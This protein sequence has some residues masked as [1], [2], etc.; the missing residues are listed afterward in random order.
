[1]RFEG[2]ARILSNVSPQL[3]RFVADGNRSIPRFWK[4]IAGVEVNRRHTVSAAFHP[5]LT[6]GHASPLLEQESDPTGYSSCRDWRPIEIRRLMAGDVQAISNNLIEVRAKERRELTPILPETAV[7]LGELARDLNPEDHI[8]VARR[9]RQGR[10]EPLG[11]DGMRDLIKRLMD[12]AGVRGLAGYDLRKTFATLVRSSCGDEFLTMRLLRDQIPGVGHRYI[13]F[14][15]EQLVAALQQHSPISQ[16]ERVT[17]H[18][19]RG[20]NAPGEQ[21]PPTSSLPIEKP[22]SVALSE[23]EMSM[24]EAGERACLRKSP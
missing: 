5:Y 10:W 14:A 17:D 1:M 15:P 6:N 22:R 13:R 4:V 20:T 18:S 3:G 9:K 19:R 16:T 24:V 8:F 12:R 2:K 23:A 7:L 11:E 21:S